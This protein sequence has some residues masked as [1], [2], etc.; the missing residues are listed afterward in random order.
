[1]SYLPFWVYF[2][3]IFLLQ[4]FGDR[5]FLGVFVDFCMWLCVWR[6][7]GVF[8]GLGKSF[9]CIYVR[10]KCCHLPFLPLF[11]PNLGLLYAG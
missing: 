2:P 6:Y 10:G 1:M 9:L 4:I 8:F 5:G 11:S 3:E 7:F